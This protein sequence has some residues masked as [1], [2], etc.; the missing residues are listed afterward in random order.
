M[1]FVLEWKKRIGEEHWQQKWMIRILVSFQR[2][3]PKIQALQRRRP[4]TPERKNFV[5][6]GGHS[7]AK[8]LEETSHA[9]LGER[10]GEN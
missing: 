4:E 7:P 8:H 2:K 5:E 9:A 6:A 10:F 1:G 3:C